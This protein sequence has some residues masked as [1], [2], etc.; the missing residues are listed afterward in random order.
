MSTLRLTHYT[1][2]TGADGSVHRLGDLSTPD[3]ITVGDGIIWN[4]EFSIANGNTAELFDVADDLGDFD[5]LIVL[6]DQDINLQIVIDDDG[7]NGESFIVIGLLAD[8]PF[9]L[10]TDDGLAGD[11]TVDNFDGTADVIERLN[12]KNSSGSTAKVRVLAGT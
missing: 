5:F 7:N 9:I 1:E 3:T 4:A 2:V 12:A 11:G 8:I 6:S 10:G